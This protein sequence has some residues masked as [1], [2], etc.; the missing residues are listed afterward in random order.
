MGYIYVKSKKEF[1]HQI[2][3]LHGEQ[4]TVNYIVFLKLHVSQVSSSS[5]EFK[6]I[7]KK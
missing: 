3:E 1:I 7:I 5:G 4:Y 2:D 6:T